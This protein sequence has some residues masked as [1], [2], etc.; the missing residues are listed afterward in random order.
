MSKHSKT[1]QALRMSVLTFNKNYFGS[2]PTMSGTLAVV[3]QTGESLSFFDVASGDRVA[4]LDSLI[5]EPH[6]LCYDETG[7]LLYMSHTYRHGNYWTHGDFSHEISI[8]DLNSKRIVDTIDTLPAKGPH[9]LYIDKARDILYSS[10]EYLP[11]EE[12]GGI[13]G[14]DLATRKI[15]KQIPSQ[16]KTHWFTMTPDGRKAYCCNKTATFISVLDLEKECM[17]GKIDVPSCEEP[18]MSLDGRF[19][20]F[21]TPGFGFGKNPS[22]PK[23]EVIDTSTDTIVKSIKLDGGALPV[24]VSPSGM[25]LV[26]QYYF[27]D[28]MKPNTAWLSIYDS[29]SYELIGKAPIGLWPLTVRC[30]NDGKIAFV[31]NITD[32]NVTV[33]DLT[34]KSV[35]KTIEVDNVRRE[36]KGSVHVGAHGL[37]HF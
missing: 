17:T 11:D 32:G 8:V 34:T 29:G 31:S 23:I 19:A 5:S 20:F 22:N 37:A 12:G 36:E 2:E 10:V 16:Y 9:G 28:E 18:S 24:H 26:G 27:E 1:R 3:S 30:S 7:K 13:V 25:I 35:V 6:E 21:P 15:I 4:R 14:I 33:I